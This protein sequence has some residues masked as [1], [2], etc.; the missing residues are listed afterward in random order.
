MKRDKLGAN[1]LAVAAIA[2]L[3]LFLSIPDANA[4]GT[5]RKR[6]PPTSARTVPV[7]PQTE[8]LIISRAED[9]P[10]TETQPVVT[11]PVPSSDEPVRAADE[12]AKT[13]EDLKNRVKSLE[14]GKKADQ[15]EKQ[16]RLLMNLDILS[17]AEQRSESL[18]KQLFEMIERESAI[19]T[20]LDLIE[21]DIRPD[22]IER[23]VAFAGTLR[24]EELRNIRKKN[25][26]VERTNLQSLLGEIQRTKT[27]LELNVQKADILVDKL[28]SK[29]EKEID[30]A[31]IDDPENL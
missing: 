25:L 30:A 22:S 19:R 5:R 29:V 24:P 7:Q 20:K 18:R 27:S 28:R 16:K 15:D 10:D 8:P 21:V 17:K 6:V 9:F 31:L 26:E 13:I 4:Q 11:T 12:S 23:S 1:L 2:G 3:G 14:S